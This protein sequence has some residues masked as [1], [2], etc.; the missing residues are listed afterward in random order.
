M[1]KAQ[2][3]LVD[4]DPDI[5]TILKDN[6]ELDGYIVKTASSGR[7]ALVEFDKTPPDL[8]ILDLS[9]PD[10]DGLQVCRLV[11]AKSVVPIIMLTARDRITD[12]VLGLESGADDYLVKPFD[13]LELAARIRVCLRRSDRLANSSAVLELGELVIDTNKT[14][15]WR[16]GQKIEL[17][18]REYNLLVFLASN[19]GRALNRKEIRR[20]VWPEGGIYEDSRAIDVH[21]QH[22]RSKLGDE[23]A[24]PQ[25]ILTLPGVGY[26]F[27]HPRE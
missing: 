5:L 6:L 27:A 22:L 3:L 12:K 9:L 2:I 4:D 24:K 8:I 1:A 15:V 18:Q 17:T 16:K 11:R 13:Y 26:M 21:V 20:A 14:A 23:S 7:A 19:S 10:V 25:F